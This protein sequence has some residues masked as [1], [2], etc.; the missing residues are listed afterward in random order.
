MPE[1]R[2][3]DKGWPVSVLER[4]Q[5]VSTFRGLLVNVAACVSQEH[6]NKLERGRRTGRGCLRL[7]LLWRHG[8][9]TSN[10]GPIKVLIWRGCRDWAKRLC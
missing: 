3:N 6:A 4:V 7:V 8:N 2:P 10:E 1:K 5:R 9:G